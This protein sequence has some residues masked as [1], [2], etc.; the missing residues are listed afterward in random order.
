VTVQAVVATEFGEQVAPPGDAVTE[1][2]VIAEP[3]SA[4]GVHATVT[5]FEPWVTVGLAGCAGRV[6]PSVKG[7]VLGDDGPVPNAFLLA[8]S[9]V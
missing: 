9:H 4:G 5:E 3:P 1:Y 8:I 2:P 6:C 7:A